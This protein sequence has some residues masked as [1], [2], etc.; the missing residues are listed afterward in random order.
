MHRP[1]P[2]F[3]GHEKNGGIPPLALAFLTFFA[4]LFYKERSGAEH[5]QKI[6]L[7]TWPRR[8]LY[9][10]FSASSNPFYSVTFSVDVTNLCRYTK[11]NGLSFYYSLIYLCTQAVNSVE[12]M[13]YAVHEGVIV[14]LDRRE[15]SFTD[16]NPGSEFFHITSVP[17]EG[18][19]ADFCRAALSASRSQTA[20]LDPS[21]ESPD[22][23]YFSSVPWFDMTAVTSE[24]DF[25]RDDTVPRITWGRYTEDWRG[26]RNLHIAIELNHRFADGL[27]VGKF[28][29]D[30]T[31]RIETL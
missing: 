10:F 26:H 19:M 11:A 21:K 22:L 25:D 4:I 6:D 20:F 31:H 13:R 2:L 14:L 9:E 24:R 16:L 3:C 1:L 7:Q 12:A 18:T 28:Y 30:L 27:H 23:I 15:P 5:M 8:E 17:C 29:E